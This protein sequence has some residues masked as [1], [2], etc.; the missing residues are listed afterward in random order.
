V[1]AGSLRGSGDTRGP[2]IRGTI[3]VW[4]AVAL[5]WIGVEFFDQGI[6]WVWG[7][8]ILTS[9]IAAIGNLLSFRRRAA[10]LAEDFQGGTPVSSV[11][12]HQP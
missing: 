12:V 2:M 5:A 9:P 7:T 4:A 10:A 8:F 1:S 11:P 6:G 3:T